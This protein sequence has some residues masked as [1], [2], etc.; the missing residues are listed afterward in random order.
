MRPPGKPRASA[1]PVQSATRD[2]DLDL[3]LVDVILAD[4]EAGGRCDEVRLRALTDPVTATGC[5]RLLVDRALATPAESAPSPHHD[6]RTP[7]SP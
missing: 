4:P 2:L 7:T 3:D 6:E 5:A 1:S